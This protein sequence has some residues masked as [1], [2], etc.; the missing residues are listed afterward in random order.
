MKCVRLFA[1]D[2]C[3]RDGLARQTQA[4]MFA[5]RPWQSGDQRC[6]S[7]GPGTTAVVVAQT[8]KAPSIE[9]AIRAGGRDPGDFC[10][11]D[12]GD[13][14]RY[15]G[16][17]QSAANRRVR[18]ANHVDAASRTERE[19]GSIGS[20][21]NSA[22]SLYPPRLTLDDEL[23][24]S[25]PV[26]V[27]SALRQRF[28]ALPDAPLV[29]PLEV[30]VEGRTAILRGRSRPQRSALWPQLLVQLEPGVSERAKRSN[31]EACG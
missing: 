9:F 3:R 1:A 7:R 16:V 5:P 4:Q 29:W 15:V 11:S 2:N 6:V 22:T 23:T 20:R 24:E 10:R 21:I 26:E 14:R 31:G 12:S 30:S 13:R 8:P 25:R 27:Q 17:N 19:S 18:D 28:E